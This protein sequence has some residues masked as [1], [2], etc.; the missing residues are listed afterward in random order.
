MRVPFSLRHAIAGL[1]CIAVLSGGCGGPRGAI[2]ATG[3]LLTTTIKTT[4]K[5]AGE[6]LKAGGAVASTG[7]KAAAS[8]VRPSVVTVVQESGKTVRR[9][10]LKDGMTLYAATKRAE[11][12][13]GVKAVQVLRGKEIIE[14]GIDQVRRSEDDLVLEKGDVIRLVK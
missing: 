9:L 7:I 6:T 8:V 12:D 1:F 3:S 2:S 13:A 10:P 4:G 14:R 11:L 5:L